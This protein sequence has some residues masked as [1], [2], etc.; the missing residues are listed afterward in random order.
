MPEPT[1]AIIERHRQHIEEFTRL[2]IINIFRNQPA[3]SEGGLRI[4]LLERRVSMNDFV[5][6]HHELGIQHTRVDD[7]EH[8]GTQRRQDDNARNPERDQEYRR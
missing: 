8:P 6:H 4:A 5:R 3:W 7:S 1:D 2:S